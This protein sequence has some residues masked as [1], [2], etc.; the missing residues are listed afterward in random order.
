L[1]VLREFCYIT[2]A[3]NSS[4]LPFSSHPH[5]KTSEISYNQSTKKLNNLQ[6]GLKK[7]N[8]TS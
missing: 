1:A 3:I 5:P 2:K 6:E 8:S 4:L 7:N